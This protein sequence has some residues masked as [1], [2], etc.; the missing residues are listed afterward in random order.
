MASAPGVLVLVIGYSAARF[1][2]IAL[3]LLMLAMARGWHALITGIADTLSAWV[4]SRRQ[5]HAIPSWSRPSL[6]ERVA[7]AILL[8]LAVHLTV[9][10]SLFPHVGGR[11]R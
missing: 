7:S 9:C 8:R 4:W 2:P 5:H 6:G 11:L 1:T 3:R 10:A